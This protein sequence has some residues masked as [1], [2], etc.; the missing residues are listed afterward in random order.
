MTEPRTPGRWARGVTRVYL[1]VCA[2]A[3][4][5]MVVETVGGFEL[6]AGGILSAFL[7]VPWSMLVASFL[8]A[9]PIGDS[10]L[11]GVL[12]RAAILAVFMLLNVAILRGMASRSESDLRGGGD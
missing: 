2:L 6:R 8:P 7:S 4:T 3:L 11:L 5:W 10:P 1:P 12:V 9:L